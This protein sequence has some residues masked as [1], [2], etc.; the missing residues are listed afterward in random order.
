MRQGLPRPIGPPPALRIYVYD[1]PPRFNIWLASHFREPGRWDQ[2]YLYS[3]DLKMHRWLLRSPHRTLDPEEADFFF[4]PAYLSLGFYDFELGLYWLAQRGAAMMR[5]LLAYVQ[6]AWPYFA[7][8][9]GADHV[10]VMTNDK[11]ATFIRWSVPQL[12]KVVLVTQW[13]WKKSHIHRPGQDVVVPPM[14]KVDKLLHESPF[15][16][17]SQSAEASARASAFAADNDRGAWRYLLSF[18][19][20][21]RFHTP[22]YSFGVR[23]KIFRQYNATEGFLLRDLRGDSTHGVHKK[24]EPAEYLAVLQQ[25]KFCL[26][27][28]GMGFSTRVYESIAQGC[29]PLIIQDDP[30]TNTSVDSAYA[31]LLPYDRFSLRLYQSDIPRLESLLRAV[32]LARWRQLRKGLACVWSRILWLHPDNEAPGAQVSVEESKR[33][34]TTSLGRES[35]LEEHDAWHALLETLRRRA[36]LRRGVKPPVFDWRSPAASCDRGT[37]PLALHT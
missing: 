37:V 30:T 14:L 1:L 32:P 27:P 31:E 16:R 33:A 3:A 6:S 10:L 9:K 17:H 19:G 18:V 8:R 12:E 28:S 20:S 15:L 21:V 35:G 22:G 25:S 4:I 29:V 2:S 24:L 5:E 34:T 7:R 26:A 23:Q 13:G 36:L 11:G